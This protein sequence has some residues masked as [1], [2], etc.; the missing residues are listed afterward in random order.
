MKKYIFLYF[1]FLKINLTTLF[2]FRANVI[3]SGISSI[4]WGIV[5]IIS[6]YILTAKNSSIY[7][8]SRNELLLLTAVYSIIIG[9]FHTIFSRNFDRFSRVIHKGELDSILLKPMDSQFSLSL[10]LFNFMSIVRLIIGVFF[11]IYMLS[12]MKVDL[13]IIS[14]LLFFISILFGILLL[15]SIWFSLITLV[16]WATNLDNLK[17]FLYQ[18]NNLGRYPSEVIYQTGNGLLFL[19]VPLTYIASV[20]AREI[21]L[22]PKIIEIVILPVLSLGFF[23]FS[24]LFWKFAL[25]NYS[26]ASV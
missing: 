26:G 17:D 20:P 14:I 11:C 4:G 9:I 6:M 24:R 18:L 12:L 25:R 13:T 2:A 8:W 23:I 3:N 19:F 5:S 10:T 22:K 1:A 21:L 7:G 15:Y 16:M